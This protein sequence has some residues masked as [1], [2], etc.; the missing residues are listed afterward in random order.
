MA[1]HLTVLAKVLFIQLI[2]QMYNKNPSTLHATCGEA[3][4]QC[5]TSAQRDDVFEG[6]LTFKGVVKCI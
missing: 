5:I 3:T 1:K 6:S 2:F 4:W